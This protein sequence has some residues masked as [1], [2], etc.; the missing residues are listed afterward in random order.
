LAETEAE[1]EMQ[2]AE[3]MVET[4]EMAVSS[5]SFIPQA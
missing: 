5:N 3:E 2:V 4:E 1:E